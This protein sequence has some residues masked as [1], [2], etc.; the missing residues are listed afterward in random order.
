MPSYVTLGS[1]QLTGVADTTG[2]NSGNWTVSFTPDIINVNVPYFEIWHIVVNGAA[3]SSFNSYIDAHQFDTNQ[4]GFQNSWDPAQPILMRPGETLY[5]YYSDPITDN[6][7]PSITIW[8][9]FDFELPVNQ[10]N[11][12]GLGVSH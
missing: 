10:R 12:G 3:G 2:N 8:L 5:F 4:V 7:P 9:R 1:R 6:T 11:A